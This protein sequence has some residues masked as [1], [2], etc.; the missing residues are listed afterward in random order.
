MLGNVFQRTPRSYASRGLR[1]SPC[2][3]GLPRLRRFGPRLHPSTEVSIFKPS[4]LSSL[5]PVVRPLTENALSHVK[6]ESVSKAYR[7]EWPNLGLS[8]TLGRLVAAD[9]YRGWKTIRNILS[10]RAVPSRNY[11]IAAGSN[12]EATWVVDAAGATGHNRDLK[13]VTRPWWD[14]IAENDLPSLVQP[15]RSSIHLGRPRVRREL[16]NKLLSLARRA[17]GLFLRGW[18]AQINSETLDS[19][20]MNYDSAAGELNKAFA[21]SGLAPDALD[22]WKAWKVFKAF[23]RKPLDGGPPRDGPRSLRPSRYAAPRAPKAV[24]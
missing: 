3:R 15:P 23:L 20:S 9:R 6:P 10:H 8:V 4:L 16:A 7:A 17:G 12:T 19:E 11:L 5:Q 21:E 18:P 13:D 22:P 24:R 2:Q 14:W 1:S